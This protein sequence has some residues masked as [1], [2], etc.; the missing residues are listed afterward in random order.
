MSESRFAW[1]HW[2]NGLEDAPIVLKSRI[3][4]S[5]DVPCLLV[6]SGSARR[7][8]MVVERIC[9]PAAGRVKVE[10]LNQFSVLDEKL[11]SDRSRIAQLP[12]DSQE[13]NESRRT[14]ERCAGEGLEIS[15]SRR[16]I[17]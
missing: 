14:R 13:S 1:R 11:K 16:T 15:T 3:Q 4:A 10:E 2:Y 9:S 8:G 6:T 17:K 12:R 5:D 7:K